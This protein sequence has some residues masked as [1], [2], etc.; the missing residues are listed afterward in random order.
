MRVDFFVWGIYTE[1]HVVYI[2]YF[3]KKKLRRKRVSLNSTTSSSW[4]TTDP[5]WSTTDST[6]STTDSTWPTTT[7]PTTTTNGFTGTYF[8]PL[9]KGKSKDKLGFT[10]EPGIVTKKKTGEE[11]TNKP[12][13]FTTESSENSYEYS[14]EKAYAFN[15][16]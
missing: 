5:T 4:P 11:T 9:K 10:V 15:D 13:R 7:R 1:T 12:P 14:D 3:H 2:Y 6:W 8:Y 16:D